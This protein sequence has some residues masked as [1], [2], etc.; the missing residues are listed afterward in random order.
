MHS[1]LVIFTA[2]A[3]QMK[4]YWLNHYFP[5]MMAESMRR[6]PPRNEVLLAAAGAGYPPLARIQ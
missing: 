1:R 3:N 2:T 6:M 4:G 5:E